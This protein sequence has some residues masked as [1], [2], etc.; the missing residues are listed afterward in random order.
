MT[1]SYTFLGQKVRSISLEIT[2]RCY[3][4]CS[5]CVR[6]MKPEL[7]KKPLDLSLD[8]IR[9]FLPLKDKKFIQPIKMNLC[10]S[11]G[12]A[13]YHPQVLEIVE[14]FRSLGCPIYFETNG[15]F[16]N[17]KFW[18]E[19]STLLGKT[20][21]LN[22]SVDGLED[23]NHLYRQRARW[24][25]IEEAICESV[26]WTNVR[27]KWIVFQ[28]NEH[29]VDAGQAYAKKLGV[30]HFMIKRSDRFRSE[31]DRLLPSQEMWNSV[32]SQ[33]KLLIKKLIARKDD[34]IKQVEI[35]PR[36]FSGKGLSIS[37]T[38]LFHPCQGYYTSFLWKLD[39]NE[40]P[41]IDINTMTLR[42][43]L[44]DS[45]WEKLKAG[46][47]CP[48]QRAE[49]CLTKCGVHQKFRK[50]Y[51]LL[52]SAKDLLGARPDVDEVVELNKPHLLFSDD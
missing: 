26:K 12:D 38:G 24:S 23:T 35:K 14:Y 48:D 11:L 18:R 20:N 45:R 22:F 9:N 15:S 37:S 7:V 27:W 13:S 21:W 50:E 29:Q 16:K 34:D 52:S 17:V 41:G 42:E 3:I 6:T 5:E 46:W 33:N 49:I 40:I 30:H 28:T 10:G 1:D 4:G 25:D 47:R 32:V 19:L 39:K 2:N 31:E 36:C 51:D 8:A 43:A 44:L